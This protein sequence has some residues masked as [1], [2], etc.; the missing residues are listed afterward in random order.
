MIC[1]SRSHTVSVRGCPVWRAA[2]LTDASTQTEEQ[3]VVQEP[4]ASRSNI[5]RAAAALCRLTA[6][7]A[8]RVIR[9]ARGDDY[10]RLLSYLLRSSGNAAAVGLLV[11]NLGTIVEVLNYVGTVFFST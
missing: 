1:G 3:Q 9:R 6:S 11:Q 10:S 8:W 5:A 7:I 2:G 4:T